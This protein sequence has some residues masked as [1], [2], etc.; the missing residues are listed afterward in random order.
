MDN[1]NQE[2]FDFAD[3]YSIV[4]HTH[5]MMK[6][7]NLVA[8]YMD[9]VGYDHVEIEELGVRRAI[10]FLDFMS[11]SHEPS[12]K[13]EFF[14]RFQDSVQKYLTSTLQYETNIPYQQA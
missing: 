2:K 9:R 7:S 13:P 12:H 3:L 5:L 8:E 4:K 10:K 6:I 1:F 14:D 11:L